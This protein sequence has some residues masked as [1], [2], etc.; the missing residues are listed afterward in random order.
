[1]SIYQNIGRH[2]GKILQGVICCSNNFTCVWHMQRR[3]FRRKVLSSE[4]AI[5]YLQT[6]HK[7]ATISTTDNS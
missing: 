7:A 2:I 1:M 3:I 6:T 4:R 5:K